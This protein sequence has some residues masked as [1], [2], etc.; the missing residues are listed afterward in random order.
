MTL[1][2]LQIGME[3]FTEQPGGLNRVY[4][5]LLAE[6]NRQGLES[7]GLVAGTPDVALESAGL[8]RAFDRV[9][10]PIFRRLQA[11]RRMALPWLRA[12]DR[13]A[14]IVSHFALHAL[15]LLDQ[16][17]T[18][19]FV[20]H[21][22]GPWGEESR[23][24]GASRATVAVKE[25]IEHQVY[26]RADAA[27]VLSHAFGE[28]LAT[29]YHVPQSRIHVVPGGV[30][31]ARFSEARSQ[32]QCRRELGWPAD[33]P[34]VL[35]VRRLVHRVGLDS[36]IAAAEDVRRRIPDLL[37]LIAGVGPLA[38]DLERW[39][40]ERGLSDTVRM[41][42]FVPDHQLPLA[43]RAADLSV[44][45][46]LALEGFG[47]IAVESLAAGTPCVVTPVGGL[48]EIIGPFSPQLIA[49]STHPA[50]IAEVISSALL[51]ERRLPS[52][53]D[54]V[55]YARANFDWPVIAARVRAVYEQVA[56]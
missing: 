20:I 53:A 9:N 3:W 51:G 34:V 44:V 13:N 19:P 52:A 50:D 43:Y 38:H 22:Q 33:R 47:L 36:L 23:I 21:F 35:C 29:R 48:T 28:I 7:L 31:M 54:C 12:H 45:P 24:E 49:D 14:L 46:S 4:G 37:I 18:H 5:H 1:Q 25:F 39:I 10:A 55:N 32:G 41:V 2:M 16:C 8:A 40:V 30:E 11:V 26:R 17:T 56:Q 6:F 15:P 42:G 27:I